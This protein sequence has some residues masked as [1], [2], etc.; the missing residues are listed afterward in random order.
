MVPLSDGSQSNVSNVAG[1]VR[2]SAALKHMVNTCLW[3]KWWPLPC[4]TTGGKKRESRLVQ[5][6]V[7]ADSYTCPAALFAPLLQ[8]VRSF[9]RSRGFLS[10]RVPFFT[11]RAASQFARSHDLWQ[12]LWH[13]D[14]V[15]NFHE[16]RSLCSF[17]R[18]IK[19]KRMRVVQL[20]EPFQNFLVRRKFNS[21][22]E[23]HGASATSI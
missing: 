21:G 14:W 20:Q 5:T 22:G 4:S 12:P 15:H 23:S 19:G 7:F 16:R 3:R 10:S 18:R 6:S 8:Q 17:P 9:C 11:N 13:F 2:A 1:T